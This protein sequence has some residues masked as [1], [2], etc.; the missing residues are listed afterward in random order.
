MKYLTEATD[1]KA[2]YN[3]RNKEL[4]VVENGVETYFSDIPEEDAGKLIRG[5]N[6]NPGKGFLHFNA[7]LRKYYSHEREVSNSELKQLRDKYHKMLDADEY[8][9]ALKQDFPELN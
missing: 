4:T 9:K 2:S 3:S 6:G 8:D 5:L 1:V 7:F